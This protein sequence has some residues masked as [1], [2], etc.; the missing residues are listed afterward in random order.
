MNLENLHPVAGNHAVQAAHFVVEWAE[1]LKTDS[2]L[3]LAKLS[4]KFKNL[5][6]PV[7]QPQNTF[8]VE[9]GPTSSAGA[10][11][12]IGHGVSGFIFAKEQ[13][14]QSSRH[15]I[16][17][18]EKCM[19]AVRDYTRWDQVFLDVQSYL[20]I[21]LEEIGPMRPVKGFGLQYNDIFTWN[22][23]PS[24]LNLREIFK[25]DFVIPPNVFRQKGL[26][27]LH[28]G[29]MEDKSDPVP[30]TVLQN[31]NVDMID[32]GAGR[33]LQ[34]IG[35]HHATLKD[36]LWQPHMK[37]KNTVANIF[38]MLHNDNKKMIISLLK[39]EICTRIKLID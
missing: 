2:I 10:M 29:Y 8:S 7:M 38:E 5:G 23:D 19:I 20:K 39:D 30:C 34:I 26:W 4:S 22:D 25:D 6:F 37:N 3:A 35:S 28:H 31:I 33:Q 13:L 17:S 36:P 24:E 18:A 27:H 21:V 15:V 16:V 12:P 1:P 9:F 32:S 11:N 14:P